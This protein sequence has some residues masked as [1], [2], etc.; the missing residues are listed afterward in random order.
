MFFWM[1]LAMLFSSGG[2]FYFLNDKLGAIVM[3]PLALGACMGYR[4]GAWKMFSM[5]FGSAC[6]F[7]LA[8]PTAVHL[9]PFIERTFGRPILNPT[10][11]LGLSGFVAGSVATIL[12]VTFGWLVIHRI[13]W[14]RSLDQNLGMI[15]GVTK[16]FGLVAIGL[17][18]VLAMEPR[19]IELRGNQPVQDEAGSGTLYHRFLGV[20]EATRNSPLL[21]N[22]VRWNPIATHPMLN[23]FLN[24]SQSM[25]LDLQSQAAAAQSGRIPSGSKLTGL[26]NELQSQ[27]SLNN[28]S[29]DKQRNSQNFGSVPDVS[30]SS[31]ISSMLQKL[32]DSQRP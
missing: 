9:L 30:S 12:L 28:G 29:L 8:A 20:A 19:M 21:S 3:I 4:S 7:Y 16:S 23:D 22:L 10:L 17:W 11:G 26:F 24:K 2:T 15:V 31:D 18:T 13:G 32:M 6:G 14:L 1:T 25:V 5:L 27:G